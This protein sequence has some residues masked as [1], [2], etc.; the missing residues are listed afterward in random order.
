MVDNCHDMMYA[1]S[2]L[3]CKN[4]HSDWFCNLSPQALAE[5]DALGMHVMIP[6]GSTLFFE[7]QAARSV[8]ILCSGHMKLTTSSKDGKTLLVRIAKPG[9]VLG[10]SAAISGTPYEITAHA[11]DPV[12]VK[13]FQRQDFLHFIERHIEGSMHTVKM[14]NQEYRDALCDATRLA[15]STCI[16]GRV[17]RLLLQLAS[18]QADQKLR[19]TMSLTHE[20]LATMLGTTRESVTRVLNEF[21]R[22]GLISIKGTSITILRKETLELLI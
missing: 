18:G 11:L 5:Y 14:L 21:K 8:Y 13:S 19:F 6:S 1:E 20:D 3:T 9:D 12:Q 15:L 4:K 10:L 17:S 7:A 22:K 16:S 2:C